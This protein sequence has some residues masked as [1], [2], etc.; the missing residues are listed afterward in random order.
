MLMYVFLAISMG[1]SLVE[2]Y[3]SFQEKRRLE[4]TCR[5]SSEIH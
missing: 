3:V 1:H 2:W 4:K 5:V